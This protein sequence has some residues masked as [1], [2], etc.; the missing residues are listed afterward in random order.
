MALLQESARRDMEVLQIS[1]ILAPNAPVNSTELHNYH[2]GVQMGCWGLVVYA[3][4]AALCS[5]LLQKY[6]D[7]YDLSIKIIY[8]LG[9]LGFSV[10][11]AVM[12]IFPNVY[13]AMVM[14]STMGVISM[15][16]SYCPYALL[17]QYH[18]LPEYVHH[19]P[20][21]SKRGFGI[22]CAILTC[23]VYISQI[24]VASALS[25]VVDAVGSV[26]VIPMVASGGSFLGF[27]TSTFLVDYPDV[28]DDDDEDEDDE[29]D[30]KDNQDEQEQGLVSVVPGDST[31]T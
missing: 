26:R 19:S 7:H 8:M 16:I 27:L 13:V 18:D 31:A 14:I 30:D 15:S 3:T 6:L 12:A 1:E 22:D 5:A 17:G 2:K 4:T 24:L 29:N 9:T 11:T 25:A 21:N 23:Q 28:P 20:G 10:G